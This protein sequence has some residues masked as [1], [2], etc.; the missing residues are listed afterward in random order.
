MSL[1]ALGH[2]AEP[3]VTILALGDSIT[4]GAPAFRSPAEVPPAGAGNPESQYA[5]WIRQK[6]PQ[7]RILN[8]GISGQTTADIL[9]R[10]EAELNQAQP[11]MV[12]LM[13][14]VNDVYRGYP[15]ETIL[16]NL[17][18]LYENIR[19]RGLPLMALTILPYREITPEKFERLQAVN[20]WI[21]QYAQ[22]NG[23]GFCDTFSVMRA[24]DNPPRLARTKDGLHPDPQGYRIL[25][26]A[27]NSA[28]ENWEPLDKITAV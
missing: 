8:R 26:E 23:L 9:V 25:G 5:Y 1:S 16:K 13:A 24:P 21:A 28:L 10:L 6:H 22:Q 14:G 3:A 17:Q 20:A 12:I 4:A 15:Q 11:A 27:V 19:R 18:A 7:W 2:A